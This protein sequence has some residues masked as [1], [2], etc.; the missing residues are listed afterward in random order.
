M[1]PDPGVAP[2][3][4][5]SPPTAPGRIA[6]RRFPDF[7]C[8]GAQKA[9]TTWL[10]ANL[11]RH[12][13]I[14]L[15]PIKELQYF[16]DLHIPAHRRWTGKYRRAHGSLALR[17]HLDR[18]AKDAWNYRFIARVADIVDGDLSDDWYGSIFTL[19]GA[20]QVCGEIT[21]AYALLP[22]AGIEHILRL[23]P[24]IKILYSLRDP[25]ERNW[26][27]IRMLARSHVETDMRRIAAYQD[28]EQHPNYPAV[29]AR[30]RQVLPTA[31]MLVIFA[32]DIAA[33]PEYVVEH[34]CEYLEIE[35]SPKYFPD[36]NVPVHVGNT[37]EI[38][39]DLYNFLKQ[40]LRPIYDHILELYPEIGRQWMAKHY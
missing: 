26:S 30:W 33:R 38:P 7:L 28:M 2:R 13:A 24:G 34:I 19:A 25:I 21:P 35:F 1:A 32:D 16:N 29:L 20:K 39:D 15:P 18:V 11:R 27:H 40:Q 4:G 23:A 6:R 3:S 14:W 10:F 17:R 37:K 5:S 22:S 8:I 12:P 31:Q 36:L 9:S